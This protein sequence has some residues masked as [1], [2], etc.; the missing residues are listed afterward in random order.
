MPTPRYCR[1]QAK[2]LLTWAAESTDQE[3]KTA[4]EARARE[5]LAQAK[6]PADPDLPPDLDPLLDE[7]TPIKCEKYS[8]GAGTNR[9]LG[10]C[11]INGAP[12]TLSP[13]P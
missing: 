4:L 10:G 7:Y 11:A 5:L 8:A 1:E 12:L 9:C 3:H 13:A 6:L 2:L